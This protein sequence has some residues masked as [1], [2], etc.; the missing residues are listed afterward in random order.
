[1]PHVLFRVGGVRGVPHEL[2]VTIDKFLSYFW[3]HEDRGAAA[4][5]GYDAVE[6]RRPEDLQYPRE[7]VCMS[8]SER[9]R[10]R[11]GLLA[12]AGVCLLGAS[13]ASAAGASGIGSGRLVPTV[14]AVV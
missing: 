8:G 13:Q 5:P 9:L 1:M 2:V 11:T 4:A 6:S 10:A 14:A 12:I 3:C 7:G